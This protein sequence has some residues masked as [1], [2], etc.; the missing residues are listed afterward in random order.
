MI[1]S[2]TV[3]GKFYTPILMFDH[4]DLSNFDNKRLI[5]LHGSN[6]SG[7]TTLLKGLCDP[8]SVGFRKGKLGEIHYDTNDEVL[9]RFFSLREDNPKY[10]RNNLV[11]SIFDLS[12]A[13]ESSRL[14][15][16]QSAMD[17]IWGMLGVLHTIDPETG[18]YYIPKKEGKF[19]VIGID[20]FD[21]GLSIENIESIIRK[22]K[23]IIKTRDDIQIF[24]SFNSPWVVTMYHEFL[25]M[26]TGER[27][28]FENIDEFAKD[29]KSHKALIEK[30]RGRKGR[31]KL[32]Q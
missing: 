30:L 28:V 13:W 17:H 5:L 10:T 9:N 27:V 18:E 23:K 31:Y 29:I 14:S 15:E 4:V 2:F 32:F 3:T 26:Y 8:H 20:E 12:K 21:S 7:K 16:G 25:S 24:A 1:N 22:F 11:S 6:G 19:W